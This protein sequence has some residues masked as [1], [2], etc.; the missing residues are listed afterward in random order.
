MWNELAIPYLSAGIWDKL[1]WLSEFWW[2]LLV[3]KVNSE[4]LRWFVWCHCHRR[5]NCCGSWV[6]VGD[7]K[8]KE[9]VSIY[10][11]CLCFQTR[12]KGDTS[13]MAALVKFWLF[14]YLCDYLLFTSLHSLL[15]QSCL[16]PK[17]SADVLDYWCNQY[18]PFFPLDPASL[19][20]FEFKL[21]DGTTAP[22]PSVCYRDVWVSKSCRKNVRGKGRELVI[23]E[24]LTKT[25]F[26]SPI[27]F[28][29]I[30]SLWK[31]MALSEV[32][33]VFFSS[34]LSESLHN[35]SSCLNL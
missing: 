9:L 11:I 13:I 20:N 16:M 5:R 19:S 27:T 18:N 12:N 24:E 31:S 30:L 15:V 8:Q 4:N 7:G 26:P 14:I 34:S 29:L 28:C 1:P 3:P 32:N 22:C 21:S 17:K 23:Q 10:P 2:W 6:F 35:Q 33:V 25:T